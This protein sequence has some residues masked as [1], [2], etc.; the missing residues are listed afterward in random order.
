MKATK[1]ERRWPFLL[2]WKMPWDFGGEDVLGAKERMESRRVYNKSFLMRA[3]FVF[4]LIK[5]VKALWITQH[6]PDDILINSI[7]VSQTWACIQIIGGPCWNPYLSLTDLGFSVSSRLL[8]DMEDSN[9]DFDE[10]RASASPFIFLPNVNKSI[11]NP[12]GGF[13]RR[14][15]MLM[16]NYQLK[17]VD[18]LVSRVWWEN[19]RNKGPQTWFNS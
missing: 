16:V 17:D 14:W 11:R 12:Q 5:L 18:F 15:A 4:W 7:N 6:S 10:P 3:S 1:M 8:G 19:H 13:R 9:P 2:L